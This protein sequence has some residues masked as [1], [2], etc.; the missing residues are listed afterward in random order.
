MKLSIDLGG[1]NVRIAQVENGICLNK[2]SVPCLAQQD[3]SAVLDQ[4]FQLIKGMMNVQVDGIGIGVPSIVDVEKGIVYN[5][6]NISSWKKIHLKDI[7]EK[8]FMVPVAINNDSNCF[9][10]GES[11][12]GEGKPYAHM[13]GVT[14]GTGIGAGVIINHRLYC[15]QYMGAGEIG[16]LPYLDSDFEHYCSSSF[17]KRHDTTGVVVAEKAERGDGAALEI[18]REFGTHLGNLMKVILFSYAPQA[19]ILG[20]SIVS[21]FHFFK[22]TMKDAMQD[23]PYKILLDNVKIITSYLKDAKQLHEVEFEIAGIFSGKKEE[24]QTG[25]SSDATENTVYMDYESSQYLQGY[26]PADY[27]LSAAVYF[28]SNPNQI[29]KVINTV[30]KSKID[31]KQTDLVK[32]SKAFEA[33]SSSVTS[34]KQIINVLTFS[35]I[36]GSI[37]VLSLILI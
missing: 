18:W 5:V 21:A 9:T 31:W 29:D 8:R 6:A 32:N 28:V 3:A 14:I 37:I 17:F 13:V 36:I 15:G 4:L 35:I 33:V 10:L 25:L 27:K 22:D 26:K 34:F 19:I 30:K 24:K 2:M 12:F 23:F 16:S 20:G 7:L 1:T 11:M